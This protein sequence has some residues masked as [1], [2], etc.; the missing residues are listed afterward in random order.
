MGARKS[1]AV[2]IDLN[3]LLASANRWQA[4][5]RRIYTAGLN[6]YVNRNIRVIFNHLDGNIATR[7]GQDYEVRYEAKKARRSRVCGKPR[8]GASKPRIL[9]PAARSRGGG[10]DMGPHEDTNR[11]SF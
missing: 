2:S 4:V 11:R 5:A 10:D 3:D 8:I 1:P 7:G 6:S 9:G